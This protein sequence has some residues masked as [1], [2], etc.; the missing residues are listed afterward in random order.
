[1][2]TSYSDKL[3][4]PRWQKLRLRILE[5]DKFTCVECG[6]I[7]DTLHVHHL[8]YRKAVDPWDYD[9]GDLITY[10]EKCHR[11]FEEVVDQFRMR[12][13]LR[14]IRVASQLDDLLECS[15]FH[16]GAMEWRN[17]PYSILRVAHAL[18]ESG[19]IAK[20][21]GMDDSETVAAIYKAKA[22][23]KQKQEGK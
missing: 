18:A 23:M 9:D 21:L 11:Y 16:V 8:I 22:D 20:T 10:C 12:M 4:D 1:M 17:E 2:K 19:H 15:S 14:G 3:K 6:T 5:R 13:R 7:T